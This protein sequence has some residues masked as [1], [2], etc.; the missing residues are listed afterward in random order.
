M[1]EGFEDEKFSVVSV[2][3]Q[4]IKHALGLKHFMSFLSVSMSVFN[5]LNR[6]GTMKNPHAPQLYKQILGVF[7]SMSVSE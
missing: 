4:F 3:M 1:G 7:S 6:L 5:L 2:Y